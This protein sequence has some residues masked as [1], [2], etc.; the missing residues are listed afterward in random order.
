MPFATGEVDMVHVHPIGLSTTTHDLYTDISP[1]LLQ[2][3]KRLQNP[4]RF[5]R[6]SAA[7]SVHVLL[8]LSNNPNTFPLR[9]S[10]N[11]NPAGDETM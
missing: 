11:E 9:S 4:F 7:D 8:F 3:L 5:L 6:E 1:F 2:S 10:N